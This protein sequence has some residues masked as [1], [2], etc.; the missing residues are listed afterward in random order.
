MNPLETP[1]PPGQP[2]GATAQVPG[3]LQDAVLAQAALGKLRGLAWGLGNAAAC[4]AVV[5]A[6]PPLPALRSY[7]TELWRAGIASLPLA[8]LLTALAGVAGALAV[9]RA[10]AALAA[11]T[12]K[13]SVVGQ[14]ARWPQVFLVPALSLP[15]AWA[16]WRLRGLGAPPALAEPALVL[17]GAATLAAFPLLVVERGLAATAETLLPEAGQLRALLLLAT[18]T[19]FGTGLLEIAAGIGIPFTAPGITLLAGLVALV[20]TELGLRAALRMFLPPP[21]AEAARAATA[22]LVAR[23]LAGMAAK[24]GVAAPL[25]QHL[26]IDFSR[27]WALAYMRAASLPLFGF[28]GLLAWGLSG[29]VLVGLDQRAIQERFGAPVAVLHP[30]LHLGLPYPLGTA[31]LI[32]FGPV[33]AIS[34]ADGPLPHDTTPAEAEDTSL[35]DRLWEQAHPSEVELII[36]S[37]AGAAQSFQAVSA[38]I[39]ILY[40]V[41]LSDAQALQAAY[42][43]LS[44]PDLVRAQAGRALASYFA[45]KT[46]DQVLGADR[47]AMAEGLRAQIQQALDTRK[48]GLEAV[49]VVIEAIHPPAGAADAYHN[50][51]AAVIAAN[52]QVLVERG[53]AT[54]I[55]A[56]SRQYAFDQ[57]SNAQAAAAENL[58]TARSTAWRFSADQEALRAGGEGFLLERYLSSLAGA[59]AK[60]PKTIIDHRLAAPENT[61]LDLRSFAAGMNS[62]GKE[63]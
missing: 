51:R 27:S 43:T 21:P 44:A 61:V 14:A 32:E 38:D 52:A 59:L 17:G 57:T 26:G 40:R 50:V 2:D 3:L 23:L 49:A 41:G 36:A 35:A 24:E 48:S 58:G 60:A 47:E 13:A 19:L 37:K 46:L 31:R 25:R 39:R 63:E 20:A 5:M 16:A 34:L 8:A 30:G 11:G 15:A 55:R 33:H 10:R 42:A 22:S 6:A 12:A 9:A 54:T 4:L 62:T 7:Q 28:L 1:K 45:S 56:Q 18:L 29:V 53:T